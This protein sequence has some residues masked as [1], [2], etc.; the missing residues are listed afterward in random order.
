VLPTAATVANPLDYTAMLW[1]H[2]NA[3]AELVQTLGEDPAV[4][5]VLV[6]YDQPYGLTGASEESWRATREAV[7]AGAA[8]SPAATLV[9]STLPELLDDGAAWEFASAGVA[10]AAGLRTGL[11]CAA[12]GSPTVTEPARLREI[13][14]TARAVRE[15]VDLGAGNWLAEHEAKALLRSYGVAVPDGRIVSDEDDAVAALRELGPSVVLKL[16]SAVV[17]HK[18][19]LGGVVV[20][21][22][23]SDEVRDAYR[24]LGTLATQYD[25][26]VLA[27]RMAAPGVELMVA[28]RTDAI[29]PALVLALGGVWTEL[30][31]DVVIV[32]LPADAARIE[33]ALRSLRGA[34]LLL[35]GRGS[36][37]ADVGAVARLAEDLASALVDRELT[38][39]ECN[40]VLV[41]PRG[42]GAVAVD[43][44]IRLRDGS[45]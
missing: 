24:R 4:D 37:P 2:R 27:E 5:R 31:D 14:A 20:G 44:A 38:E 21:L 41:G 30:L 15:G 10:A 18:S 1:G 11:R 19:E 26:C 8:R 16:S 35:G 28:V 33:G 22:S 6:F 45:E 29:V 12:V 43:A 13:A 36:E 40:P 42:R 32:P 25:G 39:V 7:I 34:P 17:Q 3:L 9:S 23:S